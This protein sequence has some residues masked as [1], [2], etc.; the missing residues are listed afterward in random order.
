MQVN[1]Q[2]YLCF[3]QKEDSFFALLYPP[4][5]LNKLCIYKNMVATLVQQPYTRYKTSFSAYEKFL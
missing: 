4:T 2:T 1:R 3:L 5:E